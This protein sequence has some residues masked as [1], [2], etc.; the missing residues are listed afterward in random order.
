MATGLKAATVI[1]PHGQPPDIESAAPFWLLVP[2]EGEAE[3][4]VE[5]VGWVVCCTLKQD[6]VQ[7]TPHRQ[8]AESRQHRSPNPQPLLPSRHCDA[9]DCNL[10]VLSYVILN[11]TKRLLPLAGAEQRT[12]LLRTSQC[13]TRDE[14]KQQLV[15][16]RDL[17]DRGKVGGGSR[18]DREDGVA[19]VLRQRC[20]KHRRV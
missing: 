4:G 18:S 8:P 20:S 2:D 5:V 6:A 1:R 14:A 3:G 7:S 12:S 15:S 17:L 19:F 16:H 10:A 11:I 9:I 13:A